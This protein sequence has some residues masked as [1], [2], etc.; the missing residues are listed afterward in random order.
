MLEDCI[1]K[2]L[3]PVAYCEYFGV[4]LKIKDMYCMYDVTLKP[5][6]IVGVEML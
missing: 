4:V 2:P 5:V 1:N 6:N 3:E